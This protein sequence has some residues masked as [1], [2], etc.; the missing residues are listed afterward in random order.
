MDIIIVVSFVLL[1]FQTN[2]SKMPGVTLQADLVQ[3]LESVVRPYMI[4]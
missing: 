3:W 1:R 4:S 2:R